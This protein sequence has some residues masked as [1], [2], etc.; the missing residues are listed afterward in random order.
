[1]LQGARLSAA[2]ALVTHRKTHKSEPAPVSA[3]HLWLSL[4]ASGVPNQASVLRKS[5]SRS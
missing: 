1:M 2:M 4:Y 3:T 5:L